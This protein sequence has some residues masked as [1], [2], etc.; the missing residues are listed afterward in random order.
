MKKGVSL[1]LI[2]S[3]CYVAN[4]FI[5]SVLL[6][7]GYF[8]RI[9]KTIYLAPGNYQQIIL[10]VWA[11]CI[12]YLLSDGI[13]LVV[14]SIMKNKESP[15]G[16]DDDD[17]E[18]KHL[19]IQHNDSNDSNTINT[20][21]DINIIL[22]SFIYCVS[23]LGYI[24]VLN[25]LGPIVQSLIDSCQLFFAL[26]GFLTL[27]PAFTSLSFVI[28]IGSYLIIGLITSWNMN[29]NTCTFISSLFFNIL[30][31]AN[32]KLF[33]QATQRRKMHVIEYMFLQSII[34]CVLLTCALVLQEYYFN[35]PMMLPQ[36]F[37]SD[38]FVYTITR[39]IITSLATYSEA[40]SIKEIGYFSCLLIQNVTIP[41][42]TYV[43][44]VLLT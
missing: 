4:L 27:S 10:L 29:I 3:S 9:S 18:E 22:S 37:M 12:L 35:H 44:S 31:I 21:I 28:I 2:S 36:I 16:D 1:A 30:I 11:S 20:N 15:K 26:V 42:L 19:L 41:V 24:Y 13:I 32:G 33:E 7:H 23:T 40:Y 39:H 34:C 8:N 6:N 14:F 17:E 5:S 38:L 25:E 43:F